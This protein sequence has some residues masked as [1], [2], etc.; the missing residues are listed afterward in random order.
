MGFYSDEMSFCLKNNIGPMSFHCK[1]ISLA[2]TMHLPGFVIRISSGRQS[3][4]TCPLENAAT[5]ISASY[6]LGSMSNL[7]G[8]I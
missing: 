4:L 1:D 5:A 3:S 8:P 7:L 6:V 2:A